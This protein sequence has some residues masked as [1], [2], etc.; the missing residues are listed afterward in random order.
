MWWS[1]VLSFCSLC[2]LIWYFVQSTLIF[3]K[4]LMLFYK[5]LFICYFMFCQY[6]TM[7][8]HKTKK[9][10][11]HNNCEMC[12][13]PIP[14]PNQPV[15]IFYFVSSFY[16]TSC[17]QRCAG[18]SLRCVLSSC[19]SWC[20][21]ATCS[22]LLSL[23]STGL[24]LVGATL[25]AILPMPSEVLTSWSPGITWYKWTIYTIIYK[26]SNQQHKKKIKM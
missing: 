6:I 4:S 9:P 13:F 10:S 16:W 21:C 24:T 11:K 20:G 2:L 23:V 25:F 12:M 14:A 26:Y 22:R 3:W 5:M 18:W 17:W 15:N 19:P 8:R 1:G 7:D